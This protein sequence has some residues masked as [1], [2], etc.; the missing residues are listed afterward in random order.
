[1]TD[2][3]ESLRSATDQ[4]SR[5]Y[6]GALEALCAAWWLKHG[7]I[8]EMV[9]ETG[10]CPHPGV[11]YLREH[12]GPQP[13]WTPTREEAERALACYELP[14]VIREHPEA[15]QIRLETRGTTIAVVLEPRGSAPH[16]PA[17]PGD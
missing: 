2:L 13:A 17:P 12:D 1:M 6:H 3:P 7:T 10:P 11:T 15:A 5:M 9:T 8:P 14:P 4:L 16:N